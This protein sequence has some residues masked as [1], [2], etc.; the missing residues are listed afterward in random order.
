MKELNN[1][2]VRWFFDEEAEK[3]YEVRVD[4]KS[5]PDDFWNPWYWCTVIETGNK[6]IF[7]QRYLYE[8]K[9]EAVN[10][11]LRETQEDVIESE[12]NLKE[13]IE[14]TTEWI[15]KKKILIEKIKEKYTR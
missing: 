10:E 8:S 13:Y 14:E 6:F 9:E 5:T 12:H 7:E 15:K 1:G 11:F 3:A 2:D 4:S